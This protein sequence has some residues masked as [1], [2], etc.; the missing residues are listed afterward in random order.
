MTTLT[1]QTQPAGERATVEPEIQAFYADV[2]RDSLLPLWTLPD[3]LTAEPRTAVR[4]HI[5]P[6]TDT[7]PRLMQAGRLVSTEEAERRVLILS[8]PGLAGRPT[9]TQSL[10]AGLQLVLPGEIARTHRHTPAALR[11][12]MHGQGGFTTVNGER[13]RLEIGDFVTTP[14]WTWHDHGNDG[15]EPVVWLD[16]L[17]FPFILAL[18]QVFF[19]EYAHATQEVVKPIDDSIR[20]YGMALKPTYE[21]FPHA[22]SPLLNYKF[23]RTREVLRHLARNG[24]G[25]PFD[26]AIV[27]YTNPYTGGS[28]LPTMAAFAQLLQP[29]QRT[30]AHRHTHSTVYM[31]SEGDGYSIV[32]GQRLD[33]TRNDVFVVPTWAPHAHVNGSSTSDAVLF[34]YTDA[35]ILK[36]LGLAREQAV[37]EAGN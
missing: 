12:I 26:G 21:Q 16:G 3:A 10:S 30:L 1:Q 24:E 13:T 6:W 35:P 11:F 7:F 25:S 33:W 8:N 5:W 20:R 22:H 32:G 9:T 29:G 27:E 37:D 36:A 2:S 15:D 19:E 14:N 23:E 31:V 34:S 28:V 4:P 17:D 18:N